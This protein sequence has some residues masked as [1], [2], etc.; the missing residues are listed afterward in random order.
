MK[1]K[2][3]RRN[4]RRGNQ[5]SNRAGR[6][7]ETRLALGPRGSA[8]AGRNRKAA[9]LPRAVLL[10]LGVG[11]SVQAPT[12]LADLDAVFANFSQNNRVCLGDGSGAFSCSDVSTDANNSYGVALGDVNG[13]GDFDAVVANLFVNNRVCL[14]DGSGA[15]ACS[16]VST[17]VNN[18]YGVALGDVNGDGDLDAVVANYNQNNRV[19]LGDGSGAFACSA[20]STDT[21]VSIGVALGDLDGSSLPP[22][23]CVP[24]TNYDAG[25]CFGTFGVATPADLDA[26]V[27]SNF[28]KDGGTNFKNLGINGDLDAAAGNLT[29]E[30]PCSINTLAK[31]SFSATDQVKLDGSQGV[32][33]GG[34]ALIDAGTTVC[35]LSEFGD[36]RLGSKSSVTATDFT[37]QATG[38]AVVGPGSRFDLGGD[39]TLTGDGQAIIG[40]K[41]NAMVDGNFTMDGAEQ[42][43]L[44]SGATFTVGGDMALTA[45]GQAIIGKKANVAVTST[46]HMNAGSRCVVGR[47]ARITFAAK[48]GNCAAQLP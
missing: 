42:A 4:S 19:C 20:V 24:R 9:V 2:K 15:F 28:G 29:I 27:A 21:N 25:G 33:I 16:A 46:L 45:D 32:A 13:D 11:A 10:A 35:L 26:Y 44:G 37:S 31:L 47:K 34:G 22:V 41:A 5:G 23:T 17:D 1:P 36:T 14:G 48:S 39:M 3:S 43:T 30:S 7:V 38:F 8:A 6:A 12:A 18:S 40:D